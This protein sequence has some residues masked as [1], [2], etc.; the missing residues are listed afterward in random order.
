MKDLIIEFLNMAYPI[1]RMRLPH[2]TLVYH[3]PKTKGPFKRVIE[4]GGNRIFRISDKGD[5][6]NVMNA[7]SIIICRM[8]HVT[9]E[10]TIPILKKHLHI[11]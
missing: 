5:K 2:K 8:F 7:L 6:Y 9:Q 10:E 11:S 4:I 3:N 1:K